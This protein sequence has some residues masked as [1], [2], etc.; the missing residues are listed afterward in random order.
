[1]INVAA[2]FHIVGRFLLAL[3][4]VLLIPLSISLAAG[5]D[6]QPFL[7]TI[8]ISCGIGAL[9]LYL[10]RGPEKD[11]S[12]REAILLVFLIWILSS[13][14]GCLPF[15]FSPW[16]SGFTDAFFEATSGFTTTGATILPDV[17]VL[18][19]GLQFWRCIT[20]WLGGMGIVLLGIAILPLVGM[21]GMSLYRAEFSGAKSEKLKPRIKETALALWKIYFAITAALYISLRIAGMGPFDAICHTFSTL[22]T[23]GFSTRTASIAAFD[24]P[25]IEAVIIVF[26][27]LAG[28]NFTLHYRLWIE[29]RAGSFFSDIE[30]RFYTLILFAVTAAIV[31][32]LVMMNGYALSSAFRV[33]L[34]QVF[35]IMT[36]T[37]FVTDNFENW[38]SF[39]QL[40][41]L[42]LMF[43]GGSTGSTSGGLKV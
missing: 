2:L 41:L 32:S 22:G 27:F 7:Y 26:M 23:G 18:P 3:G 21:G 37:G 20:H 36:T 17:E 29:R 42:A 31:I 11:F 10:T 4:G 38:S 30:L 13:T 28:I 25:A 8:A 34:F 14:I 33:S 24:S 40:M 1:M 12:Q 15:Y 9:L 35:S 16:F 5:E 39:A 6:L 43:I 19:M